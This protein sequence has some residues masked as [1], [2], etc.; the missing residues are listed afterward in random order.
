MVWIAVPIIFLVISFFVLTLYKGYKYEQQ[1]EI[2]E[3]LILNANGKGE[4]RAY[5]ANYNGYIAGL[6]TYGCIAYIKKV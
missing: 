4:F 2:K 1:E 6:H 3:N 5:V